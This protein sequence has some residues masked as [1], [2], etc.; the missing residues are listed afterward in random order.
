MRAALHRR[1]LR[2]AMEQRL[3]QVIPAAS[4]VVEAL[5]KT[6]KERP[7]GRGDVFLQLFFSHSDKERQLAGIAR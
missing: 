3:G 7:K 6:G 5:V 2:L 4:T 1:L